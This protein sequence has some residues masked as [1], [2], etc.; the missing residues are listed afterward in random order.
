MHVVRWIPFLILMISS[1]RM[2]TGSDNDSQLTGPRDGMLV[3]CMMSRETSS[4][5][6]LYPGLNSEMV[7]F[8]R[9]PCVVCNMLLYSCGSKR[10]QSSPHCDRTFVI[11]GWIC[12]EPS[13][14]TTFLT[15]SGPPSHAILQSR[16]HSVS[17]QSPFRHLPTQLPSLH[18]LA[19]NR[20]SSLARH[21]P[22]NRPSSAR[23]IFEKRGK[24]TCP[25][26]VL[27][28]IPQFQYPHPN[29][30]IVHAVCLRAVVSPSLRSSVR[31]RVS[32]KLRPSRPL[33]LKLGGCH[34]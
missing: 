31:L 29:I 2:L 9:I 34:D 14:A 27:L 32:F 20:S 33:R 22:A 4:S 10:Q 17:L 26:L 16:T 19:A 30:S 15:H 1:C 7:A 13:I 6:K 11:C 18:A 12:H 23:R 5:P 3:H 28:R 24:H 25:L 21:T 8:T